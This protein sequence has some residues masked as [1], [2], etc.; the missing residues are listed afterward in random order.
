[1]RALISYDRVALMSDNLRIITFYF[2]SFYMLGR[3]LNSIDGHLNEDT[4]NF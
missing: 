3:V 4:P 2:L 1:M